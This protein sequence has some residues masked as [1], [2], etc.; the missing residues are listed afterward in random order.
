[1][2]N[3]KPA[4]NTSTKNVVDEKEEPEIATV[5]EE[6]DPEVLEALNAKKKPKVKAQHE[7]DYIP[8]LER[9]ETIE[10]A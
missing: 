9:D 3:I 7:I 2:K 10:E 1:M 6:L 4:A 8:E 5:H